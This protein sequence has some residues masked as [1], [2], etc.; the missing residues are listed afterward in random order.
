MTPTPKR[1]RRE[2]GCGEIMRSESCTREAGHEGWHENKKWV[3]VPN[4]W[5]RP[6]A[7]KRKK[8]SGR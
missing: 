2:S 3:W 8:E 1:K 5:I 4:A 6:S 7:P